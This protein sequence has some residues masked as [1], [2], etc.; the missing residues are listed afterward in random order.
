MLATG[1]LNALLCEI[2]SPALSQSVYL[3]FLLLVTESFL[4]CLP[5][6]YSHFPFNYVLEVGAFVGG[7][8]DL[9][10]RRL[11]KSSINT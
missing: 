1:L 9:Q 7:E 6:C 4:M 3:A 8:K 10:T 2:T 11:E 5:I